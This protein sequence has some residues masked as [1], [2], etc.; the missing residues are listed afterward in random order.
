M[1]T[2]C[3]IC[4]REFANS[5]NLKRHM[6]TYHSEESEKREDVGNDSEVESDSEKSEKSD[7]DETS[8]NSDES[9]DSD[10]YTYDE[11]R[12]IVRFALKWNAN[13]KE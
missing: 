8:E 2:I 11:V 6:E 7:I 1:D 4:N 10:G 3:E 5:F 12:A 13:K 9:E